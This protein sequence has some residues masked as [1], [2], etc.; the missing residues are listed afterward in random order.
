MQSKNQNSKLFLSSLLVLLSSAAFAQLNP[1]TIG[2]LHPGDSIVVYYDVTIN[3]GCGC[4][5][6]SNQGSISGSNFAG[7]VTNDPDT[8]PANDPTITLLNL[9]P[10]PVS[11]YELKA[12]PKSGGI[13]VDWI[14]GNESDMVRYEVEKSADGRSFNKIGE[15]AALNN[16][17]STNYAF[18][19]RQPFNGSNFYR[20]KMIEVSTAFKYSIIVRVDLNG[21]NRNITLYPNPVTQ[22]NITLQLNNLDRGRYRLLFYNTAGQLVY[23]KDMVHD[24]GSSSHNLSLPTQMKPGIYSAEL[25]NDKTIHRQ[26]LIIQ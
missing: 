20:L 8:G 25:K 19:D 18:F 13:S 22:N 14:A 15:V 24:G 4:T 1:L 2:T 6:I 9:F 5:Q 16:A 21:N 26:L 3:T 17:S 11:L 7:F 10:L 23:E 12:A